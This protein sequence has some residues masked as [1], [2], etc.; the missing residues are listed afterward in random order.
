MPSG[1]KGKRQ[2]TCLNCNK[3]SDWKWS[4]TNQYCNHACRWEHIYK[5]VTVPRILEG[6]ISPKNLKPSVLKF[7]TERD[8][9]KCAECSLVDWRGE[10]MILDI[11]HIDGNNENNQPSNWRL[12][13]PNCHRMTP[14]WGN[15]KRI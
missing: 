6:D 12:L 4:T 15:K 7:L 3:Q 13:C 10:Q 2:T 11:D 1:Q 5:T 14:T 9:Y 8:G